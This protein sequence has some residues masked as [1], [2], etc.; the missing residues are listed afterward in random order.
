M[1]NLRGMVIHQR[2]I[3]FSKPFKYEL[4]NCDMRIKKLEL[5]NFRGFEELVIDFPEGESGLAVF[6][7]VNGSGKTSVLDAILQMMHLFYRNLLRIY[8][9][10]NEEALAYFNNS[11][12]GKSDIKNNQSLFEIDVDIDLDSEKYFHFSSKV[13]EDG[14]FE[15]W[16]G[17]ISWTLD[18]EEIKNQ[19][20]E[21][22]GIEDYENLVALKREMQKNTPFIK[23]YSTSRT[24]NEKPSL[25][26]KGASAFDRLGM[27][28]S[29]FESKIN[30]DDFFEWFRNTEDYE[31]EQRLHSN[32][33]YRHKGLEAVRRAFSRFIPDIEKPRVQR[34]PKEELVVE[35]NGQVLP[36]TK[37]SDGE[38]SLF[39]LIG[40]ITRRLDLTYAFH[41]NVN[42]LEM[43]GVILI[44]EIEQHLH[45]SW[46]RTIIPNLRRTFPNIQFILTTHSPQVLSNVPRENVFILNN[47]KLEKNKPHTEGRDSNALLEDIFDV[48]SRPEEEQNELSQLYDAIEKGEKEKA[49]KL[50]AVLKKK[51]GDRDL[52]LLRAENYMD[53]L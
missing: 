20:I 8:Y 15:S 29:A 26:A 44:D 18:V 19:E 25:K 3:G 14:K 38:K 9:Q 12:F 5:K 11:L 7:G 52:E 27:F 50:F 51:L 17:E 41:Q 39:A 1:R 2:M 49:E 53:V 10:N 42:I 48:P 45:P 37:L 36:L 28:L 34:Q 47:F 6:V 21:G 22:L 31:N 24:I 40:D 23:Y 35:K 33:N 46:Q 13:Y 32:P 30:Y 4:N 16:P 43:S